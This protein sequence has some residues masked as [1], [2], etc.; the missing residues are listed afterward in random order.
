MMGLS[1]VWFLLEGL[2]TALQ[3]LALL[4]PLPHVIDAARAVILDGAGLITI[5]PHLLVLATMSVILLAVG[6][7]RFRWE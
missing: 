5:A 2:H 4:L 6:S 1:G 3:K 7:Y